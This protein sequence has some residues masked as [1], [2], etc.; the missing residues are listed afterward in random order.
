MLRE[1][2]GKVCMPQ[3][4]QITDVRGG[5]RLNVAHTVCDEAIVKIR[6]YHSVLLLIRAIDDDSM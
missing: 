4:W 6:V 3:R 2:R 5:E 1:A